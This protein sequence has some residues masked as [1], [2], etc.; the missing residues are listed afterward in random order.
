MRVKFND[1]SLHEWRNQLAFI[2][3]DTPILSGT[4]REN[5]V[6]GLTEE[7]SDEAIAIAL[8]Q[9]QLGSFIESLQAGLETQVGE[10]GVKLSGGQKQRL[11]I[12]RA[13]LQDAPILLCDEATSSLDSATE[14]KIQQAMEHLSR[15]RTTLIAAHRLSTVKDADKIV[16]M[17]SGEIIGQ[18]THNRLVSIT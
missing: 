8:V 1:F 3:Q 15:N 9:A 4:I 14:L 12:A 2:S 11:A 7:P 17:K 18:G 16:V 5:L 13:I 6:I 10:R